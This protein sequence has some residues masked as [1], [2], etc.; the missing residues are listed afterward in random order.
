MYV[1]KT[2]IAKASK[3]GILRYFSETVSSDLDLLV[4]QSAVIFHESSVSLICNISFPFWMG[5]FL[6]CSSKPG[7]KFDLFFQHCNCLKERIINSEYEVVG[8]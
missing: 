7:D 2:Y 1:K 8:L 3:K 6:H 5:G 4:I